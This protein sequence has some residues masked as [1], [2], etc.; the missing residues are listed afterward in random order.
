VQNLQHFKWEL[1]QV[2]NQLDRIMRQ[3]YR[4]IHG[5]AKSRQVS[6]RTAAFIVAIGRVGR[7]VVQLGL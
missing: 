4:T 2:T 6:L 1:D 3:S 7:A 5:L